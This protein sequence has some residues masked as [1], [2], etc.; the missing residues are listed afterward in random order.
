M[1]GQG[2]GFL[3]RRSLA[4]ALRRW[5]EVS[6]HAKTMPAAELKAAQSQ[7]AVM[8]HQLDRAR[9]A[10]TAALLAS[11]T[12]ADG[13]DRPHQCDW[14]YRPGPWV[15]PIVPSGAVS[16]PS[17]ADLG[18]GVKLFHDAE[19]SE[20]SYRQIRNARP[21]VS[22]PFGIVLDVYRFDGSFLSVVQDLP[23]EAVNGLTRGHFLKV[24]L[25]MA[26]ESPLEIYARLNIQHGPNCEQVV[27][28]FD[29]KG[30][31]AVA[32]FDLAY[33]KINENRLEKMWLDLIFEGPQMNQVT[34]RDMT[35]SR[36]PRAEL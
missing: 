9:Q 5:T 6:D 23:A 10:T 2:F 11:G 24:S 17:P 1:L 35:V 18:G 26:V 20:L 19:K 15:T 14:A 8:R 34:I 21:G 32:E 7:L 4:R 12:G 33:T 31:S 3:E 27:R 22:A 13:I 36:A 29:V 25:Q 28:Q 16:V 30:D